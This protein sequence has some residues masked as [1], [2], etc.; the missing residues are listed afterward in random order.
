MLPINLTQP[1]SFSAVLNFGCKNDNGADGIVFILA[2][3]N[4]ALGAGGGSLGYEGISPS[5]AVEFDDFLNGWGDPPLDHMAVISNGSVNH[6]ASTNLFGPFVISEVENCADHCFSFEW[7]PMLQTFTIMLDSDVLTYTI[8][9]ANTIFNGNPSVYYGFSASTG[10]L[11]NLQ[12][13]CIGPPVLE[14]M[15]DVTICQGESVQLDADAN[16]AEWTWGFDPT[17]LSLNVMSPIATP[18][19]NTTYTVGI[20][21]ACGG[22]EMDTVSVALLPAPNATA[23]SDG[24]LCTGESLNLMASGGLNYVW[25]GPLGFFSN[26]Q[27]PVI[28]NVTPANSGIYSVTVTD[29]NGCT[30]VASTVVIVVVPDNVEIQPA[31]VPICEES[32]AVQF[33]GIPDQGL[34]SGQVSISGLFDP[35]TAG[36][37]LHDL[38][39][40]VID[41]NGC[42]NIAQITIEVIPNTPALIIPDG[43]FCIT[44]PVQ[45]LSA[46]PAGGT[47]GEGAD[48]N[49][50][51]HPGLLG[52][53]I[54]EITYSL[55]DQDGCFDAVLFVEVLPA[56]DVE[57]AGVGPFCTNE[58]IQTLTANPP[59]GMWG[60]VAGLNGSIDPGV[61]GAGVHYVNYTYETSN[62]CADTDTIQISVIGSAPQITGL[63]LICDSLA[64]SYVVT[65]EIVGGDQSSYAISG[66][67]AGV[68]VPGTPYIYTSDPIQSGGFYS[69]SVDDANHC[70]PITIAGNYSCFCSTNSGTMSPEPM[71]AC[72]GD[73]IKVIATEGASPDPDDSLVYV[74]HLGSGNFLDSII[75][76]NDVSE[77]VFDSLVQ[78]GV[79]YYISAVMGN[80]LSGGVDLDDPCLSVSIGT[81]VMW[82]S[83]P[84]GT[85]IGSQNICKFDSAQIVFGL[86]GNGPFDIVYSDGTQPLTLDSIFNGYAIEVSPSQTTTYTLLL[87]SE[88]SG[89]QCNSLPDAS[90][91][92][93]VTEP[94]LLQ[95]TAMIC[96]GDSIFLGNDMQIEAGLY[97]DSLTTSSGCDSII[98]TLLSV[99]PREMTIVNRT[100]CDST[101]TGSTINIYPDQH[102]CD[103]SVLTTIVFAES[104]TSY[105]FATTCDASL[106]GIFN[107]LYTTFEGCDS[108]V[109]ESISL[110]PH[111]TT[112]LSLATCDSAEAGVF[113]YNL[114]NQYG[115]DSVII[116]FVNFVPA[117]TTR[118]S[119]ATCD[120]V[121]SGVFTSTYQ[122]ANGCDSI[123]IETIQ[124]STSW[125]IE[126]SSRTCDPALSG[127][128]TYEY[129]TQA[130]CD[131]IIVRTVDLLPGDTVFLVKSTCAP[132]DTGLMIL[133]LENKH[134][135]DSIIFVVTHLEPEDFCRQNELVRAVFVPNVFSPNHDGINDNFFIQANPAIIDR[136][137]FLR[138]YDRWGEV[139]IAHHDFPP[140]DPA[141]GW[142]GTYS[143]KDSQP[144]VYVWIAELEYKDGLI[145]LLL[146]DVTLVR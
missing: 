24:V 129:T 65:F 128:F 16:G 18:V 22:F 102:G 109:I 137:H 117:D 31:P 99:Y 68:L 90:I 130:G 57:I 107:H 9:I 52:V 38:F 78:T 97:Y 1:F 67:P 54:H 95:Q 120:P 111:D 100:S 73:T 143:N 12:T 62:G 124:W 116:E 80:G 86:S 141:F 88:R 5:I 50:Q 51:I 140:N 93:I 32:E 48:E 98:E 135:C 87:V 37:G 46:T 7:N 74:L 60:G 59:G 125:L 79:Q 115:C 139:L 131:S 17:L 83:M 72:V 29:A 132:S 108:L 70:D 44:D 40:T 136:V 71:V 47:W 112:A 85:L 104:D 2:T 138:V 11:S 103:S 35:V 101:Q 30:N 34:W 33:E 121:S 28:N 64:S 61:L 75:K 105:L 91:T 55:S 96:E 13:V 41:G 53:G 81:P 58:P 123:V 127:V 122:N 66:T 39:Y 27:N 19:Q 3:S 106:T 119:G 142:D 4:T 89:A 82:S 144:G 25:S 42:E 133:A 77:F 92:I 21:Y 126:E 94:F 23:T 69:I 84:L 20:E 134:G 43:P 56:P 145:E 10:S 114:M 63:T 15:E 49:G 110:L 6:N 113:T 14:P 36:V 26:S 146:G 118:L 76:F 8:D 45:T